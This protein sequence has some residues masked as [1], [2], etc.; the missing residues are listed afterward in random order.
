MPR[1]ISSFADKSESLTV[2]SLS[3]LRAGRLAGDFCTDSVTSLVVLEGD[4]RAGNLEAGLR[5]GDLREGDF[6]DE[7]AGGELFRAGEVFAGE[8]F[9]VLAGE[10]GGETPFRVRGGLA[11]NA[12]VLTRP[13]LV[14]MLQ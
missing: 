11:S 3:V 10:R 1:Y 9:R 5:L 8:V 7:R 4:L 14:D 6:R 2:T 13:L 12:L